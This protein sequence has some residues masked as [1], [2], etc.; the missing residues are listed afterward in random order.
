[1]PVQPMNKLVF[2]VTNEQYG[3][4][5]PVYVGKKLNGTI[6]PVNHTLIQGDGRV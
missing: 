5:V 3:Y 2:D 6:Q 1:M 4:P